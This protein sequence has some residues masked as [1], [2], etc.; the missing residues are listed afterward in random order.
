MEEKIKKLL[1]LY[2]DYTEQELMKMI[3][4]E[5]IERHR[6]NLDEQIK[7]KQYNKPLQRNGETNT[8]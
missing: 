8:N 2:E 6:I 4:D 5:F 3:I 7:A 1:I